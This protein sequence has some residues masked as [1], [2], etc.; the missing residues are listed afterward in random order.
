MSNEQAFLANRELYI[1]FCKLIHF[2]KI[3]RS[4][5]P[6][7]QKYDINPAT[8]CANPYGLSST[9]KEFRIRFVPRNKAALASWLEEQKA[10]GL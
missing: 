8:A 9:P 6:E 1:A 7:K 10:A 4:L 2:F 5:D 3:E